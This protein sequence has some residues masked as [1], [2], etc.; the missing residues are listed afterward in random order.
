[1]QLGVITRIFSVLLMVFSLSMLPPAVM[2]WWYHDGGVQAFL[3]SFVFTLAVGFIGWLPFR[4]YTQGLKI[5]DGFLVVALFWT[6]LSIFGS[7]PFV[8]A[9]H[10][11]ISFTDAMFETVSGLTTTG[12]EVFAGLDHMPHAIVYYRDQLQFLGGMGIIV[13]AVAILP[14]LGVGGMQLYRAETP[15][16][17]KDSKLS[18]RIAQTA[19]T[20]W[21]IYVG[22]NIACI[23]VFWLFGMTLYDAI[24]EAFGTISTGGFSAHDASFSFYHNKLI[25]ISAIIFMVL[26]GTNFSLH[27]VFLKNKKL[28][29]LLA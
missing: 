16:P 9:H 1:M 27:Y 8:L 22:L 24:C 4:S 26:G 7:I 10:L 13:L 6:I 3:W 14:M 20:L 21:Y 23:L 19:K 15:G 18:P 28:Q 17:I 11:H 29:I 5:R 12:S 25:D 2:A